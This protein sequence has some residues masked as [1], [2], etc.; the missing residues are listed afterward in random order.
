[1]TGFSTCLAKLSYI[2]STLSVP[3]SIGWCIDQ[4]KTAVLILSMS[5]SERSVTVCL[6][7]FRIRVEFLPFTLIVHE[8]K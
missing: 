1:M 2:P 8:R 5:A 4:L 3:P 7:S 6:L